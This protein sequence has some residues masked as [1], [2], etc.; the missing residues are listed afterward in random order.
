M[1]L[2]IL[3]WGHA[4]KYFE[5]LYNT[6][7]N[8]LQTLIFRLLSKSQNITNCKIEMVVSLHYNI[9]VVYGYVVSAFHCFLDYKHSQTGEKFHTQY[10]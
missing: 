2:K 9:L 1:N 8:V 10:V 3:T 7:N 4:F 6:P 5:D